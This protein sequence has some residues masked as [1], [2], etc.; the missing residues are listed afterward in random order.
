MVL[1]NITGL[2]K[3]YN[4]Q[5]WVTIN[6]DSSDSI[7]EKYLFKGLSTQTLCFVSQTKVYLLVSSLDKDNLEEIKNKYDNDILNIYVYNTSKEFVNYLEDIIECLH[8][9]NDISL[10]FSTMSDNTVDILSHGA[11]VSLT[12]LFKK[13]YKKYTKKVNFSS[14]E[15]IIYDLISKKTKLQIERLKELATLTDNILKATFSKITIGL[16]EIEIVELTQKVAKELVEK[17]ILDKN[18]IVKY[19]MAWDNCP[20]V[21][22]GENLAKGG[23]SLPSEKKLNYGD[24][25]YF[26]FGIKIEYLD[27]EVLYTD[28]QRMGYAMEYGKNVVPK[29]VLKV[30]NTLVDSIE[31]GIEEMKPDVKGY[32]IDNIVRKKILKAGYPDYNHATGHPVGDN[33]HDA[34]AVISLKQSKRANLNLIE[35]GVYTLE[36]RVNISNGGSIEEMILVTKY[37]GVPLCDTQK[38]LYIVK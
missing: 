15:N 20:I 27:G 23:H 10:S 13:V 19:D 12:N 18:E 5:V 32:V 25:I 37:G 33:V 17:Y 3:K 9:P 11:Y 6:R 1:T 38:E 36:P 22:T 16:T 35:D 7:F 2:V 8:F 24:T 21:L 29:S 34:G 26:D 31:C 30:F 28:M 14:A 4:K